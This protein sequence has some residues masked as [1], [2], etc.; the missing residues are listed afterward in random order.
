MSEFDVELDDELQGGDDIDPH[1]GPAAPKVIKTT[2]DVPPEL[3][4]VTEYWDRTKTD[5]EWLARR[6]GKKK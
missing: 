2:E 6:A 3:E 1:P 5:R 4:R